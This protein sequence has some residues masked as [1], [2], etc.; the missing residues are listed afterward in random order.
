[1]DDV[2]RARLVGS[3]SKQHIDIDVNA[4]GT[5]VT[6]DV[7]VRPHLH[8]TPEH[9]PTGIPIQ[10]PTIYVNPHVPNPPPAPAPPPPPPPPREPLF[11]PVQ[12][13]RFRERFWMSS[14]RNAHPLTWIAV[15]ISLCALVLGV[16]KGHFP[17]LT[18]R[19]KDLRVSLT[20]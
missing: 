15:T 18:G 3:P 4:S 2:Y 13:E 1:M 6:E 11:I 8:G 10:L 19:H 5:R 9:E 16:P 14:F 7:T 20:E 17:T 12:R